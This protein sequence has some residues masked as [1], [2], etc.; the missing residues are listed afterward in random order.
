RSQARGRGH[1]RERAARRIRVRRTDRATNPRCLSADARAISRTGSQAPGGSTR[2]CAAL[3]RMS[4]DALDT[5]RTQRTL[6]GSARLLFALHLDGPLFIG[7]CLIGAVGSIIIFSASGRS[8]GYL[9][10]QLFRF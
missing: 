1:R 10:A 4:Y 8:F 2:R 5:S 9:E 3:D 6:T 7:L